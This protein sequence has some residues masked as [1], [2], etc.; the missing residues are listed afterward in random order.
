[1]SL[2]HILQILLLELEIYFMNNEDVLYVVLAV[3]TQAWVACSLLDKKGM[4][5]IPF[6]QHWQF[7]EFKMIPKENW[8]NYQIK[9]IWETSR[10]KIYQGSISLCRQ[11]RS[12]ISLL[13]FTPFISIFLKCNRS[14]IYFWTHAGNVYSR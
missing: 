6:A 7:S 8:C 11:E 2:Q 14:V 1:M 13:I 12:T 9:G 10:R 4:I 3:F 5:S